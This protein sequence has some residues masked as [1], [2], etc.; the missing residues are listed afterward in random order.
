[1]VIYWQTAVSRAAFSKDA[2]VVEEAR[3]RRNDVYTAGLPATTVCARTES[4]RS[5]YA[6]TAQYH[7]TIIAT[8][9]RQ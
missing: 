9:I 1:M 4:H 5:P 3:E 7:F 2:Y 6:H 8:A